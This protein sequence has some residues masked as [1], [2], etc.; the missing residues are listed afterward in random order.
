M[1]WAVGMMGRFGPL[2]IVML[3]LTFAFTLPITVPVNGWRRNPPPIQV[4]F[5]VLGTN[6]QGI[7]YI[8]YFY[9]KAAAT[10]LASAW[11]AAGWT[12]VIIAACY[13]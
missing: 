5:A 4:C 10:Q 11:T 1:G 12:H 2:L 3:A 6:P 13:G 7:V 9:R 8:A